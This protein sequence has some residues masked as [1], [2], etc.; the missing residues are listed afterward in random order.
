[1][2]VH[3]A[4]STLRRR[5][6][7]PLVQRAVTSVVGLLALFLASAA[8]AQARPDDYVCPVL[9][10]VPAGDILIG[11]DGHG[12]YFSENPRTGGIDV[13]SSPA[14]YPGHRKRR[15]KVGSDEITESRGRTFT[16][17]IVLKDGTVEL[18]VARCFD[19]SGRWP[20]WGKGVCEAAWTGL[21]GLAGLIAGAGCV[22]VSAGLLTPACVVSVVGSTTLVAG[23][24][25]KICNSDEGGPP[26]PQ[27]EPYIN[28][29]YP[30]APRFSPQHP[31]EVDAF[32]AR[33]AP[34]DIFSGARILGIW[35]GDSNEG[36]VAGSNDGDGDDDSSDEG[37]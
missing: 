16:I 36:E 24:G 6:P 10:G 23:L 2:R 7:R 18:G 29:S 34:S 3:P 32:P 19:T 11:P 33:W 15:T 31:G 20:S 5:R 4:L 1:M 9:P 13:S 8:S 22:G 27:P 12:S 37:D 26:E 17:M 30:D 35:E 28:G 14:S 25:H 21:T